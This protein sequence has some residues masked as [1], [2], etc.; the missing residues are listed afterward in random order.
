[1]A[2]AWRA[3]NQQK[4]SGAS[5]I[6]RLAWRALRAGGNTSLFLPGTALMFYRSTPA[7]ALRLP[8]AFAT[9]FITFY[10]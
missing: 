6:A 10:R 8:R 4:A 5:N 2:A 3:R 7:R 1:M 9:P